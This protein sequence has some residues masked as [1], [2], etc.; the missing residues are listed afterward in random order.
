MR[1][2]DLNWMDVEAYL[3][4]DERLMLVLGACEQHG[5]LSLLTDVK[6]PLAIADAASERTGVLVA[7]ALNFGVSPSFGGYPGTISLRLKTFL[8]VVEDV[9]RWVHR[10]G[11]RRI[12]VLNGHGGNAPARTLLHEL[13]NALPE[14]RVSWYAWWQA[15]STL[16]VAEKH[17][18]SPHHAAWVEAFPFT[19]VGDLPGGE[20]ETVESTDEIL[21]AQA[22]RRLLGDGVFGGPYQAPPDVL[23]ELF[24]VV[25]EDVVA[26]LERLRE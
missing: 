14:M 4:Q 20:K 13:A 11:F 18:L 12:L 16:A 5:Y 24:Q 9:V 15:P 6:I 23:D 1:F 19:R 26:E 21:D 22:T 25:V 8:Q 7:P 17:G 3:K 10:Q 2:E